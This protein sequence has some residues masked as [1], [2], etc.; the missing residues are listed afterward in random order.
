MS[1]WLYV[2]IGVIVFLTLLNLKTSRADGKLLTAHHKFRKMMPF[3][4]RGRNES[5]V[6]F[7]SY[8]NAEPVL[9]YIERAREKGEFSC[10]LTHCAVGAL[11]IGFH[12]NPKMNRF[13]AGRRL[14]QRDGVHITFSMK[15]GKLD[16][17]AKVTINK[18]EI[19]PTQTFAELANRMNENIQVERSD[20]KT[21]VDKELD[22]LLLM[23]RPWL[24][25]AVC[26]ARGL[27][28][29][30]LLPGSFIKGDAMFASVVVANRGS[31]NMG[32]GYHHLYE[33]GTASLFAMIG[34]I[35]ENPVVVDGEVIVQKQLHIRYS[36]DERI[37]DGLN[38][39]FGIDTVKRAL[40]NPDEYLGCLKDDGSDRRPFLPGAAV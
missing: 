9:D 5:V 22:L 28:Y 23:P 20:V 19:P 36:Y 18:L 17:E 16:R 21:Y 38:A 7:D 27:D 4:M 11:A 25:G 10:D 8:I 12:E 3:L 1:T 39:R 37:D 40:E 35:E 34:K 31:L 30:G 6:Y 15:R 2:L 32:A 24:R 29:Y 33:W 13:V 14:Y 26:F